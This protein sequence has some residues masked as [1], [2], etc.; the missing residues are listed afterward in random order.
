MNVVLPTWNERISPV[1][2]TSRRLLIV[3]IQA[4]GSESMREVALDEASPLLK[5]NTLKE[6]GADVLICGAVSNPVAGLVEAAN[7]RLIP[8][9]SGGVY[10][11]L[12]AFKRGELNEPRFRMPGCRRVRGRFGQRGMGRGRGRGGG[13]WN[14]G[15]DR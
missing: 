9:V 4:D 7:I 15:G 5:V 10:E 11:I 1:F 12:A 14:K 8:W 13:T 3:R 2:D 6:L